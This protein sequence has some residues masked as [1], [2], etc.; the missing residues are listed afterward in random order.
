MADI[1]GTGNDDT[2]TGTA[3]DDTIEGLGGN[4]TLSGGG[5]A[6]VF[7]FQAAGGNGLDTITDFDP[8]T[9]T[10]QIVTGSLN[11]GKDNVWHVGP[12]NGDLRV[13]LDTNGNGQRDAADEYVTLVGILAGTSLANVNFAVGGHITADT[14]AFGDNAIDFVSSSNAGSGTGN[15]NDGSD[16]FAPAD[17][18]EF[19]ETI[20]G[21]EIGVPQ[22]PGVSLEFTSSSSF[23]LS[24]ITSDDSGQFTYTKTGPNSAEVELLYDDGTRATVELEYES[25]TRVEVSLEFAGVAISVTIDIPVPDLPGTVDDGS[26]GSATGSGT[27]SGSA[28]TD[29]LHGSADADTIDGLGGADTLN[30]LAGDDTLRG[31]AGADLLD[32][33]AGE[34]SASYQD[35]AV[36]VL[37]RLHNARAVRFGDA[38]GDTLTGIEHLV[39]SQHNDTLAG[40]GEDNILRGENGNDTLYG[41]PAGG[42]DMMYGGSGDDRIFGGRGDDVLTGGAGN[43]VMKGGP[44]QDVLVADGD[45]MDILYGGADNDRFQ[46]FPSDLGGG[47]IRDFADGEDVIDLS[48]FSGISSMS[49]LDIVSFG[50]NVRIELSSGTDYLT[51]I[52]LSDFDSA[53]LD[54]SDFMF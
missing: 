17:Q 12:G 37:V 42:D 6:D 11:F 51:T 39:G 25:E 20:D 31:G 10:L 5:G 48:G 38:E 47:I 28:D 32:G 18:D 41:G 13:V 9:D 44:G 26:S 40:D 23:T 24:Q 52:I 8:A 33:G 2:L 30:G 50:N 46:F 19:F 29:I 22:F 21:Q 43:D 36:G 16:G 14:F 53:N 27:F 3:G 45:Y 15:G 54:N 34:D 4:D 49:D 35:S 7:V 1:T